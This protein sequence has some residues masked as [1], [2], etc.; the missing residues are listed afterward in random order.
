[1]VERIC[2]SFRNPEELAQQLAMTAGTPVA[3]VLRDTHLTI[4]VPVAKEQAVRE[5]L[6]AQGLALTGAVSGLVAIAGYLF[7]VRELYAVTPLSSVAPHTAF[8]SALVGFGILSARPALGL[9]SVI[10][11]HHHGGFIARRILPAA[12][13]LPIFFAWLG[14]KGQ[15]AGLFGTEFGLALYA[16]SNVVLFAVVVWWSAHRL[17][18]YDGQGRALASAQQASEARFRAMLEQSVAATY[19]ATEAQRTRE[20]QIFKCRRRFCVSVAFIFVPLK[21]CSA[22]SESSVANNLD[23]AARHS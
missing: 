23:Q 5:E 7:G 13:F 20:D 18:T 14:L 19:M 11:H 16:M 4:M 21:S 2:G 12:L 15:Q 17:N 6:A 3:P 9:M 10:T 1:M 22:S 8:L